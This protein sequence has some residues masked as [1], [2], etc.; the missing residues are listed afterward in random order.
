MTNP[1][2]AIEQEQFEEE[3]VQFRSKAK[4]LLAEAKKFYEHDF[5]Q[6]FEVEG[7]DADNWL[8]RLKLWAEMGVKLGAANLCLAKVES[9]MGI[10][11][12]LPEVEVQEGTAQL[13]S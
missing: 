7:I 10:L 8:L 4:E 3:V 1:Y 13:S 9:L 5:E 2:T 12:D 6:G 11:E